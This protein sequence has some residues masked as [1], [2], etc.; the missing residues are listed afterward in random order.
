MSR[1][2]PAAVDYVEY[3]RLCWIKALP[4][5]NDV[6]SLCTKVVAHRIL[7]DRLQSVRDSL[8]LPYG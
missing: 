4:K 8:G 5:T 7:N 1:R 3:F 6:L 2:F